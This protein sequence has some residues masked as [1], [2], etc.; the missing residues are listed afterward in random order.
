MNPRG[1][2]ALR[3][4]REEQ[5][6][7]HERLG[8][9]RSLL[10]ARTNLALTLLARNQPGDAL[11]ARRLLDLALDAARRLRIPEAAQI[12]EIMRNNGWDPDGA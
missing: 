3:I 10:V 11:E 6:P 9:V 2:K 7:V 8:N 4:R 5:L 12:E 1:E